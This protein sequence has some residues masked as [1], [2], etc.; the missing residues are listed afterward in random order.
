M[1]INHMPFLILCAF[2]G[3]SVAHEAPTVSINHVALVDDSGNEVNL[4]CDADGNC[5]EI[6]INY[7]N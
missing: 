3:C 7:G 1:K 6:S 4:V 2:L 5:I